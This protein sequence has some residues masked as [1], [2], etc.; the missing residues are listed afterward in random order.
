MVIK[1]R[2]VTRVSKRE[3]KKK[4]ECDGCV[5]KRCNMHN[6]VDEMIILKW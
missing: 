2:K 3:D 5:K 1:S 4:P 6:S